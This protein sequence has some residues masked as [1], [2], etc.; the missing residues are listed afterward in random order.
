[1][2]PWENSPVVHNIP[3]SNTARTSSPR[4]DGHTRT[5]CAVKV[6]TS[7]G[8]NVRKG[9]LCYIR[10]HD[11]K[12]IIFICDYIT[13]NTQSLSCF[14]DTQREIFYTKEIKVIESSLTF[15]DLY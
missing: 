8:R 7:D 12:E 9:R 3:P 13:S 2:F 4:T 14:L 10:A 5:Q 15:S 1:M 11:G 6:A